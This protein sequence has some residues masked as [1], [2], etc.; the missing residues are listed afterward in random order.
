MYGGARVSL[1]EVI[2]KRARA[3]MPKPRIE[4]WV[5][6]FYID[7]RPGCVDGKD[8]LRVPEKTDP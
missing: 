6:G 4:A 8:S 5:G 3:G 7:H 2:N 1:R